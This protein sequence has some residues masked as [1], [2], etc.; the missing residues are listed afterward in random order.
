MNGVGCHEAINRFHGFFCSY[1][2][3]H[4]WQNLRGY[5]KQGSSL[6]RVGKHSD[7]SHRGHREHRGS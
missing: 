1:D 5:K 3:G 6:N 4:L 2:S 7:V